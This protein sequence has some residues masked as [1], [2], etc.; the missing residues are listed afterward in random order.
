MPGARLHLSAA[1][2]ALAPY[3]DVM[4]ALTLLS[5]RQHVALLA[6]VFALYA[7]WRWRQGSGRGVSLGALGECVRAGAVLATVVAVY[8]I[9]A[10]EPRPMAALSLT[11]V[12]A[13]AVDFHSH[14]DASWDGRHG[15]SAE[16]NRA[17]HRDAGFD[18]TYI[19][20]HGTIAAATAG[21]SRNPARA[22][23][24]TLVLV[25]A[26]VRCEGQHVVILGATARDTAADCGPLTLPSTLGNAAALADERVALLTIPGNLA[27]GRP[28]PAVRAFEVADGA[29]RG[30]EQMA[31]DGRRMQRIIDSAGLARVSGS[32]NHGWG[33]TTA[34]WSVLTIPRWRTMTPES[35]DLAIRRD[36]LLT[37]RSTVRVV[38]RRRAIPPSSPIG[39]AMTAPV[40]AW[41]MLTAMSP[42]ERLSWMCWIW[43]AWA[44][45]A[46][47]RASR[48][49]A[50]VGSRR[51]VR[52]RAA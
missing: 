25:A 40:A 48:A 7:A 3:C 22:G 1:Y 37:P 20:D 29:P 28:L 43:L 41:T 42:A 49:A 16:D 36:L 45:V 23:A 5:I 21:M 31:R 46:I 50:R 12:N 17:W 38:E 8:T 44:C 26:E 35:L 10:L 9:G 2:L 13:L 52:A 51:L 11:D 32:N 24:G 18:V 27:G 4:D 6:T 19:S 39:L 33:R 30:M 14:T 15:F 34:A 47:R